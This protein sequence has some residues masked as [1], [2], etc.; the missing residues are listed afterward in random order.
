MTRFIRRR[1]FVQS[2]VTLTGA[3]ASPAATW[4]A[5]ASGH[6]AQTLQ[7][8]RGQTVYFNAWA[9]D[10][11]I[12]AYIQWA[13]KACEQAHGVKVEHVKI[14]DAADVVKRVRAEKSAGRGRGQ[15]TV[16][17]IWINGENFAAM[18]REGLLFGPFAEQ[19]PNWKWVDTEGK[20]TTRL[21]F[22]ETTD[23]LEAPWGMA[24]LTFYA[25][26]TRLPSPPDSMLGLM[27]LAQSQPGR[28]TY[29]APPSFH[30]TTFVKQALYEL[31]VDPK[32]LR[33]PVTP[34]VFDA[35]TS[36]LW[37][38]L[39][40]LHPL[41][42]RKGEQFTKS[43][44]DVRALM[45]NGELIM[46]LTFNPNE[47]ASEVAAGRM[48]PTTYS[49]QFPGGTIGNTH[50]VAIPFNAKAPQGA[51]VF[52]NFLL[53]PEAQARKAD[54]KYWGDPTVLAVDRLPETARA[55]FT[56]SLPPGSVTNPGPALPEP[57]ASWVEALEAAWIKRY[58][59]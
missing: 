46:G 52:A 57:H 15:G 26:K 13:A 55:P 42:W 18:K 30:G 36:K 1:E 2:M 33:Q 25:D 9:G 58:G 47:A 5:N 3:A 35:Q 11:K 16:D 17:L 29:P 53:S 38:F 23:G 20:P 37:A 56:R 49:W 44:S 19:L 12:N 54:I 27:D 43:A 41:L 34:T 10:A 22:S 14:S 7:L 21:D 40:A 48:A 39:D 6:W 59:Q 51:Q 24:Q 28:L 31:A 32:A 50:F 8:A 45:V 4:A